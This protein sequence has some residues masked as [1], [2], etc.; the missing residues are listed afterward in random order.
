MII[1][2]TVIAFRTIT[3]E[4]AIRIVSALNHYNQIK[5]AKRFADIGALEE[6]NQFSVDVQQ[7]VLKASVSQMNQDKSVHGILIFRPL[8]KLL[9]EDRLLNQIT[10]ANGGC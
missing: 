6:I 1:G 3:P 7:V 9:S 10:P 2:P 5:L 8:P 4:A